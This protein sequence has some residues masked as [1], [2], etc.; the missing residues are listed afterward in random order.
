MFNPHAGSASSSSGASSWRPVLRS[1]VT[2]EAAWRWAFVGGVI[3]VLGTHIAGQADNYNDKAVHRAAAYY[4]LV[5]DE[6]SRRALRA[7]LIDCFGD[8]IEGPASRIEL[9]GVYPLTNRLTLAIETLA[10]S[11]VERSA[12]ASVFVSHGLAYLL[13]LTLAFVAFRHALGTKGNDYF[14]AL[15]VGYLPWATTFAL[16]L[17]FAN[18]FFS[19]VSYH[20]VYPRGPSILASFAGT[21]LGFAAL[22]D[23]AVRRRAAA[24]AT[25]LIALG[26]ALHAAT[27]GL[28]VGVAVAAALW[29]SA[30]THVPSVDRAKW[31]MFA[32]AALAVFVMKTIVLGFF[33]SRANATFGALYA[34]RL[35]LVLGAVSTSF[36]IYYLFVGVFAARLAVRATPQAQLD[37]AAH[38]L[39]LA[40]VITAG[41]YPFMNTTVDHDVPSIFM[42]GELGRRFVGIGHAAFWMVGGVLL[43]GAIAQRG[44]SPSIAPLTLAAILTVAGVTNAYRA[45][46]SLDPDSGERY[47]L[48]HVLTNPDNATV[49][50]DDVCGGATEFS[51]THSTIFHAVANEIRSTAGR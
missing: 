27:A 44:V 47:P 38:V 23:Q 15:L 28:V 45:F 36:A 35:E 6:T 9:G 13:A 37:D 18:E 41:L 8:A 1:A 11:L 2:G 26:F 49:R 14:G 19:A 33:A 31:W 4:H 50:L 24:Y 17:P 46:H 51:G 16:A 21:L 39:V 42:L 3:F 30:A 48:A 7:R 34:G 25:I 40:A 20:T 10:P 29:R 22:R 43:L 32:A 5:A 12:F